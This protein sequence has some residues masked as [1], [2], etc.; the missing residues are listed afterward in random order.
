MRQVLKIEI[1]SDQDL[2]PAHDQ[3]LCFFK[4]LFSDLNKKLI[5]QTQLKEEGKDNTAK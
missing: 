1:K 4:E 3:L 5:K 2:K